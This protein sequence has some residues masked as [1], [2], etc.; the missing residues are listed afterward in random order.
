VCFWQ[1]DGQDDE[2]ADVVRGGPNSDISLTMGRANYVAFGASRLEDIYK[3]R[4]A[5]PEEYEGGA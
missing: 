5:T 2:D 4:S 1:D 3:V